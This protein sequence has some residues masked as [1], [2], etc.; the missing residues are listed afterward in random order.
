MFSV[1]Q[2][3]LSRQ[4]LCFSFFLSFISAF[5]P[6]H[7]P[8]WLPARSVSLQLGEAGGHIPTSLRG[9]GPYVP[10]GFRLVARAYSSERPEAEFN[11]PR[12]LTSTLCPINMHKLSA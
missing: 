2:L 4:L 12:P 8:L 7:R 1:G 5:P 10:S 3:I 11:Y 6:G 9:V